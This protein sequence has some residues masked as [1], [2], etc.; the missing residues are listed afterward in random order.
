MQKDEPYLGFQNVDFGAKSQI[1]VG[2]DGLDLGEYVFRQN[3][4]L[5]LRLELLCSPSF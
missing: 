3:I 5:F 4:F 1:S 2:N